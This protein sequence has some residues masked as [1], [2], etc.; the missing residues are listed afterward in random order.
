MTPPRHIER[1]GY[2]VLDWR[3][4]R[5]LFITDLWRQFPEL[6]LRRYL[7]NTSCDSGFL[8][9]SESEERDGWHTVGRLAHSPPIR[10]TDQIPHDQYDEWLIFDQPTIVH[11]FETMVNY[12]GF[13]PVDFEWEEKQE[14]FWEQVLGLR[15]LHVIAENDRVYLLSRDEDLIRRVINAE[16]HAAPNGGPTELPASPDIGGGPLLVI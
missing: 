1:D 7:V 16:P 12:G 11:A 6:I 14:R 13:T 5:G 15:P 8:T 10:S 9:L 4:D 3:N 2:H